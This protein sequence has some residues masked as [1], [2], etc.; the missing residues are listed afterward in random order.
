M[1]QIDGCEGMVYMYSPPIL[2]CGSVIGNSANGQ[3]RTANKIQEIPQ[4]NG[5]GNPSAALRKHG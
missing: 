3:M 1:C 5:R 2:I 4:R